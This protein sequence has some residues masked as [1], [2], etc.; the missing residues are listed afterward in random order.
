MQHAS[1]AIHNRICN[2]LGDRPSCTEPGEL[3]GQRCFGHRRAATEGEQERQQRDRT[4]NSD[5][6]VSGTPA[7]GRDEM[8]QHRRPDSACQIIAARYNGDGDA[9]PSREPLRN[10]RHQWAE[11]GGGAEPD[12]HVHKGEQQEIGGEAGCD[13]TNAERKG[14]A[15]ERGQDSKPIGKP[16]HQDAAEGKSEH[17]ERVRQCCVRARDAELRLYCWQHDR[18]R[19]QPT[20]PSVPTAPAAVS[21]HQANED[22]TPA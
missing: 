2:A 7:L 9:A 13:I 14:A 4:E 17:G 5:A 19:P 6:G 20:P 10:V 8:L 11:G 16:S 22:S 12:Q 15:H 21:R 1:P 3:A 18:H